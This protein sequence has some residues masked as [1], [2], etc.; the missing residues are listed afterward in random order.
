M[1]SYLAT[2][3]TMRGVTPDTQS[4]QPLLKTF[5]LPPSPR[6]GQGQRRLSNLPKSFTWGQIGNLPGVR[7]GKDSFCYRVTFRRRREPF[8][9]EDGAGEFGLSPCT[10]GKIDFLHKY[11]Q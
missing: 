2:L 9:R 11:S 3:P 6:P 4:P 10:G 8:G 1:K 7:G 5:P